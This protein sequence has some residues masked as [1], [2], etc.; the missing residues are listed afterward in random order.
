MGNVKSKRAQLMTIDGQ[1]TIL[2]LPILARDVLNPGH[3]LLE[4]ES[5][6]R[7]GSRAKPLEPNQNLLPKRL[8]FL[9]PQ[10][11]PY[12]MEAAVPMNAKDR[13]EK[14][15]L[16]RRSPST[17]DN[18]AVE[19]VSDG[20]G[21]RMRVK[22]RLPRKEVERLMRESGDQRDAAASILDLYVNGG[23]MNTGGCGSGGVMKS[24]AHKKRVSFSALNA[25]DA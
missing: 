12:S 5:V 19:E 18:V 9:V 8:Y 7:Y 14:L 1:T 11:A 24:P 15:M 20:E 13:L 25:P 10:T 3:V 23:N 16:A 22:M 2:K 21:R 4:A 6:K 17:S